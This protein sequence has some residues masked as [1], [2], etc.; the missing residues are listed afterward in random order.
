MVRSYNQNQYIYKTNSFIKNITS[1]LFFFILSLFLYLVIRTV[2]KSSLLQSY[3]SFYEGFTSSSPTNNSSSSSSISIPP[4]YL[5][6]I[7]AD[8]DKGVFPFRFLQ[9]EK[10]NILPIVVLV[11]FFRKKEDRDLFEEYE[12]NG[13]KIVG[14]TAYKTFPKPI[15]DSTADRTSMD[16]D[17]D[18]VGRVKNWL[19]CFKN[20]EQYGFTEKNNLI[21]ISESD[22]YDAEA[23]SF[24]E[25]TPEKKYDIIYSC[26]KDDKKDNCSLTGWNAVNRNYRLAL[27]CLPIIVNEYNMKILIVGRSG[28]GLEEKY[29]S[30]V[31][32]TDF[33]PYH[34]FQQKIKESRFLF[35]PNIYDASPRV[36]PEAIIKDVPVL[37]N[38]N[39]VCGSKYI[40]YNTG[41]FFTDEQDIRVAIRNLIAKENIIS[42]RKWWRENYSKKTSGKKFRDFLN[43]QYPDLMTDVKEVYYFLNF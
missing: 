11:A 6:K 33:L 37:M 2:F 30:N 34:E 31:E 24:F 26:L 43:Q 25:K 8:K 39:I 22:F 14:V 19:C 21:E 1:F 4:E 41:E 13:V 10:G 18:Y 20:P 32:T 29:G 12:K 40:N 3:S 15:A 7:K 28:C 17:F 5:N 42:P 36:V 35:V 38:R 16:D 9:D 27:E 23:D